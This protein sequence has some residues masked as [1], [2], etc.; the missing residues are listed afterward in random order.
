MASEGK[1]HIP[2]CIDIL[3]TSMVVPRPISWSRQGRKIIKLVDEII[4]YYSLGFWVR[5][6]DYFEKL[7]QQPFFSFRNSF[8]D[9]QDY[10][11]MTLPL[12][13]FVFQGRELVVDE[14]KYCKIII[15]KN[16]KNLK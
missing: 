15:K 6:V 4:F 10:L 16:E 8:D 12:D 1:F 3:S 14:E 13:F 7:V 11:C 5:Y 2:E 9:L